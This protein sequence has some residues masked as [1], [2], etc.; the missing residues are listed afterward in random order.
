MPRAARLAALTLA[1]LLPAL[2]ALADRIDGDWCSEDGRHSLHI[3]GPSITTPGGHTIT[4]AYS[5][6]AFSYTV[7]EGEP[8]AGARINMR[9]LGET[10]VEVYLPGATETW[11]RSQLSS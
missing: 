6:H 1:A 4:G 10:A 11:Q 7:P 9:L 5:R 3:D 8:D 2:P